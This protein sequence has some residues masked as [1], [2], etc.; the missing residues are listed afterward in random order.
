MNRERNQYPQIYLASQSPRRRVLLTWLGIPFQVTGARLDE[1][2][3]PHEK[4]AALVARLARQKAHAVSVPAAGALPTAGALI[5]AADTVV[6]LDNR[7]L[8]K[9]ADVDAARAMLRELRAAPHRVH[10]GVALYA[11]ATG[12]TCTR[13]VTTTVQLRAYND[14]EIEAYIASGDPFDKAGSYA[15]QHA[16]FHPVQE[17]ARCYANVVGLPLCAVAALLHSMGIEISPQLPALCY[18]QFGYR[19]P[20]PDKGILL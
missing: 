20:A 9:P 6:E 1:T 13:R 10:T 5:L 15:I 14:A 11:P 8:G 17:L 18:Q 12:Q 4:P 16:G 3:Y 19:C 2:P 7:V